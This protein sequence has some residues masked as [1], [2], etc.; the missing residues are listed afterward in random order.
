MACREFG[1]RTRGLGGVRMR[2]RGIEVP[3][4]ASTGPVARVREV[5]ARWV[6]RGGEVDIPAGW[7]HLAND[8]HGRPLFGWVGWSRN[9]QRAD[10]ERLA[11]AVQKRFGA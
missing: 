5:F 9:P 4:E 6:G 10:L 3:G 11:E 7:M 2:R 1:A 8:Q